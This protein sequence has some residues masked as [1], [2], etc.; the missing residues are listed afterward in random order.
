MLM[1]GTMSI[2]S[3]LRVDLIMLHPL[4]LISTFDIKYLKSILKLVSVDYQFHFSHTYSPTL[5]TDFLDEPNY[6][7]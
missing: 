5:N 6:D 4:S 3:Y 7:V 2:S 1:H